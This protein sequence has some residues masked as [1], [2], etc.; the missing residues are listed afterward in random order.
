MLNSGIYNAQ[1]FSGLGT[2]KVAVPFL[3][4]QPNYVHSKNCLNSAVVNLILQFLFATKTCHAGWA[5]GS[6]LR[7]PPPPQ[8][9]EGG[10]EGLGDGTGG[11][12]SSTATPDS[13]GSFT[14]SATRGTHCLHF[15]LFRKNL[16]R[17]ISY[18]LFASDLRLILQ[19]CRQTTRLHLPHRTAASGS[20]LGAARA[21]MPSSGS[22]CLFRNTKS[23]SL[24]QCTVG[25]ALGGAHRILTLQWPRGTH[26]S[27]PPSS[28]P[29][30]GSRA[31]LCPPETPSTSQCPKG[32]NWH[33]NLDLFQHCSTMET[34]MDASRLMTGFNL[35]LNTE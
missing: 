11:A 21:Q 23:G 20:D 7:D 9:N 16:H 22:V 3:S 30:A 27:P 25:C 12:A 8:S 24:E 14:S 1:I 26:W 18:S 34:E 4:N 10:E 32:H 28:I 2:F 19:T 35:C 5:L 29:Q 15:L 31:G 6:S 13:S 17:C 33:Q